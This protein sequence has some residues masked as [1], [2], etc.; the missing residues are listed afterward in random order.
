MEFLMIEMRMRDNRGREVLRAISLRRG[1]SGR[2]V[3]I[4]LFEI[5]GNQPPGGLL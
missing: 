2:Y 1:N 3:H 5:D 4:T